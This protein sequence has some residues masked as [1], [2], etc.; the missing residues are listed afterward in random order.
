MVAFLNRYVMPLAE[1]EASKHSKVPVNVIMFGH[2]V[3]FKCL[4]RW[5]RSP[6]LRAGVTWCAALRPFPFHIAFMV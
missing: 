1:H 4:L 3:A 2:A 6:T 5:V